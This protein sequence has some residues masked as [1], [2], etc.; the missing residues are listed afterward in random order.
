M[1]ELPKEL[2]IE[3]LSSYIYSN[4]TLQHGK[5]STLV[6]II[7]HKHEAASHHFHSAYVMRNNKLMSESD[8]RE[9]IIPLQGKYRLKG[10]H[11]PGIPEVR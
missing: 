3:I 4:K 9:D 1:R 5:L 2:Q 11:K 8:K 6:Q 7:Q 10:K